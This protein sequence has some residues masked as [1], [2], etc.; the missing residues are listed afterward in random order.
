MI[1]WTLIDHGTKVRV[2][3]PVQPRRTT[4][5]DKLLNTPGAANTK[6]C[7][8]RNPG[9]PV[10][11]RSRSRSS[12][13]WTTHAPLTPMRASAAARLHSLNLPPKRPAMW[14]RVPKKTRKSLT[15]EVKLNIIH[16]H[17]RGDKTIALLT[18]ILTPS[19]VSTIFKSPDY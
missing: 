3:L 8:R 2:E 19:T 9:T 7:L 13:S 1:S 15:L 18:T 16:R 6:A 17:E 12:L 11:S 14:P 4:Q 5:A 10:E